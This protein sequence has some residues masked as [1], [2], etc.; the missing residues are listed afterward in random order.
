MFKK[1]IA[2]VLSVLLIVLPVLIVGCDSKDDDIFD[3][4][5]SEN[6]FTGGSGHSNPGQGSGDSDDDF[7]IEFFHSMDI[8]ANGFWEGVRALDYVDNIINIMASL[9][10]NVQ[11]VLD[12][13]VQNEINN[14]VARIPPDLINYEKIYDRAVEAGDRVNIDY[15]GSIDG[16][17]FTGGSTGGMGADVTAGSMQYI[18]DFLFQ[19]IGHMPG[20]TVNVEVTFPEDYGNADLEGKDALFVTVINYIIAAPELND[21]FVYNNFYEYYGWENVADMENE[22]REDIQIGDIRKFI[23]TVPVRTIPDV[24]INYYQQSML[25]NL[26]EGAMYYGMDFEDFLFSYAGISSVEELMIENHD[27]IVE[28]ATLTLIVQAIA[29]SENI[30]VSVAEMEKFFLRIFDEEDIPGLKDEFGLPFLM[31]YVLGQNVFIH[32]VESYFK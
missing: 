18:D 11:R 2:G 23:S 6:M 27:N 20:D 26:Y 29:E 1:V 22:I 7:V 16:V 17:E 8:N 14:L 19:I 28:M 10:H 32:I 21:T 4:P 12:I 9:P 13:E 15:V 30:T 3:D 25:S 24:I 5:G 31:Q